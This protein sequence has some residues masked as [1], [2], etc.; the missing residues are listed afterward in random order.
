M[1][2][3]I[4]AKAIGDKMYHLNRVHTKIV[5]FNSKYNGIKQDDLLN[6]QKSALE[7]LKG[8]LNCIFPN[9]TLK[10]HKAYI[11][12]IDQTISAILSNNKKDIFRSS[13]YMHSCFNRFLKECFKNSENFCQRKFDSFCLPLFTLELERKNIRLSNRINAS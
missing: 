5:F 8:Y 10:T 3:V 11:Q 9:S 7:N 12:S 6:N 2:R 13:C 4:K 1:K